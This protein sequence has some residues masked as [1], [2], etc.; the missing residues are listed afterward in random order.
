MDYD[1]IVI[2]AGAAG[3]A[4]GSLG[5]QLG[6]K[7]A[8]VERDLVGGQCGFWA[9]MP[10]KTLLDSAARRALGAD[11]PWERASARRDWMISREGID[12]P[13]DRGHVSSQEAA[14]AE[15][16][17][18][19]ARVVAPGRV[20]V[21]N[22]GRPRTLE[23]RNLVLCTGSHPNIPPVDGLE[24]TGY[25]TS[26][27]VTSLRELPSSLV[28]MG[29]GA[30]GVELAQAYVRFGVKVSMVEASDGI[31]PREHPR[32]AEILSAQLRE[33]GIEVTTGCRAVA[34]RA[35][36]AGRL[37]ELSNGKTVQGAELMVAVGRRPSDLRELGVEEAGVSLDDRGAAKHDEQMRVANGVFVAGDVAGGFQFTHVADYEGRIAVR[38]ALGQ[39]VR[40][41]LGT[42][43]RTSFT[44][45]ETSGVGLSVGEA[46]ERGIEAEEF[47]ADFSTSARG[48]TIEP[49]RHSQ[50]AI[51]EGTAGHITVVADRER[52]VLV[53]AFAACPGASEL[54][55][56]AVLAI[57]E[58]IP[59]AA[60]ADTMHAFPT[61]AR[62]FGNLMADVAAQLG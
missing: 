8:V 59:V 41:H 43:P 25:W 54:I 58:K 5:G 14:G 46:R 53:G 40:A 26:P 38:A 23:A 61:G 13:D 32:T 12:Y 51:L 37:V 47:T 3:E 7:V 39:D 33:E 29:G 62:V 52:K 57:K 44:D 24:E 10:S 4:A 36:G 20:E 55:H 11:Y 16:V 6:A 35:E 22:G 50:K 15:V 28:V 9:C 31:L 2:G 56:E 60:V 45:P 30:V 18:G 27:K 49:H 19:A 17:R 21:R 48:F 1:V 34:V 42:I